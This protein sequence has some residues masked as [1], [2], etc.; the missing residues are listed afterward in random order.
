[1]AGAGTSVGT[2]ESSVTILSRTRRI[3]VL[4]DVTVPNI[5]RLPFTDKS[6][7]I[8][9]PAL[10]RALLAVVKAL[11]ANEAAEF[12]WSYDEFALAKAPSANEAAEFACVNAPLA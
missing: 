12:A 3:C 8:V 10:G 4:T 9:P 2:V 7:T 1:M 5:D 11:L 6:P